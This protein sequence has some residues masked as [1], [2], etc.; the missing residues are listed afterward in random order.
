MTVNG[1][2]DTPQ[3]DN[4]VGELYR[5]ERRRREEER[6]RSE[7]LYE[8]TPGDEVG[9]KWALSLARSRSDAW[10]CPNCNVHGIL[11]PRSDGEHHN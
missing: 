7:K 11:V 2:Y 5:D 4:E 9:R 10:S 8:I 3:R 1:E 6:E